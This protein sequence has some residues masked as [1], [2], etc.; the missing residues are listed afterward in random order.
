MTTGILYTTPTERHS[1]I[2]QEKG[3]ILPLLAF[4]SGSALGHNGTRMILLNVLA[5]GVLVKPE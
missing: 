3:A 2:P 4:I 1:L 5:T